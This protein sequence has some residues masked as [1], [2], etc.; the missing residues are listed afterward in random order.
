MNKTTTKNATQPIS[1]LWYKNYMVWIFVIGLPVF[2]VIACIFFIIYSVQIKD[3][4]VRDDWYMDGK[5]LYADVSKDKLAHDLGLNG[6]MDIQQNHV[7]F[8]LH[9]PTQDFHIPDELKIEISHATQ[10]Q[11]DRDL[12]LKHLANGKFSGMVDFDPDAGK[13]YII[14]HNPENSWRLRSTHILPTDKKIDFK[15]L[16]SF[17][18]P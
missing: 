5:T 8:Q 17:D 15:P 18:N 2:V 4:V 3:S 12:T 9:A 1:K 13:Y 16:T 11:K 14:V 10:V 7:N 6:V